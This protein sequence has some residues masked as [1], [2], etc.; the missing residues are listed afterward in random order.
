M[1][2]HLRDDP[3]PS[4]GAGEAASGTQIFALWLSSVR[5]QLHT[6]LAE[7]EFVILV[8]S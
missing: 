6:H 4:R 2:E 3:F 7:I 8:A 1:G 5:A